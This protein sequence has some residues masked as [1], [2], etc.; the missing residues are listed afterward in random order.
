MLEHEFKA[1]FRPHGTIVHCKLLVDGKSGRSLGYGFVK[2]STES[3]ARAAILAK[4]GYQIGRK[5]LKVS[6]SRP[7]SDEIKNC[8]LYVTNLPSHY[9]ERLVQQMFQAHGTVIECRVLT[10]PLSGISKNTAFVQMSTRAEAQSAI[11]T[12][13]GE[14]LG[15]TGTALCVKFAEDHAKTRRLQENINHVKNAGEVRI[16]LVD[17]GFDAKNLEHTSSHLEV[18]TRSKVLLSR[19]AQEKLKVLGGSGSLETMNNVKDVVPLRH[20]KADFA[21]KKGRECTF[22]ND[23]KA[24][25]TLL[26]TQDLER[27]GFADVHEALSQSGVNNYAMCHLIDDEFWRTLQEDNSHIPRAKFVLV[28]KYISKRRSELNLTHADGADGGVNCTT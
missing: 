21:A 2:F 28:K 1:L 11:D 20:L 7:S 16:T 8:K 5:R 19:E 24:S 27:K 15:G 10:D 22:N 9:F 26:F 17:F 12:L 6:M 25:E 3:E 4:N 23:L 13:N 14:Q 18:T